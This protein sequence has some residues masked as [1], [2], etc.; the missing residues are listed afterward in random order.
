MKKIIQLIHLH[1]EG[2]SSENLPSKPNALRNVEISSFPG[3]T[4]LCVQETFGK[5]PA[6]LMVKRM[7]SPSRFQIKTSCFLFTGNETSSQFSKSTKVLPPLENAKRFFRH[8][9]RNWIFQHRGCLFLFIK[10]EKSY[11]QEIIDTPKPKLKNLKPKK[12][13]QLRP[14]NVFSCESAQLLLSY[15]F[16]FPCL[17]ITRFC[18]WKN[19]NGKNWTLKNDVLTCQQEPFCFFQFH[20]SNYK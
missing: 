16:R 10:S 17:L 20:F 9:C 19:C 3:K 18:Y 2:S 14:K 11:F 15:I 8:K 4:S 7:F 12:N 6:A 5:I 1:S 13:R